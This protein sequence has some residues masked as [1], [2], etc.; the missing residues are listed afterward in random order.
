MLSDQAEAEAS[1]TFYRE[2]SQKGF[3]KRMVRLQA[4]WLSMLDRVEH[5]KGYSRQRQ[6]QHRHLV[7]EKQLC[8]VCLP[9]QTIGIMK[10]GTHI[11][12]L[13]LS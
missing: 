13:S 11:C 12:V 6:R 10:A 1:P 7:S 3:L 5:R 4:W 2:R 8:T 9:H